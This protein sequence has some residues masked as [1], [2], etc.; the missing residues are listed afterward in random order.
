MTLSV[1]LPRVLNLNIEWSMLE[2]SELHTLLTHFPQLRELTLWM[3]ECMDSLSFLSPVRSTLRSLTLGCCF[4]FDLTADAMQILR[5][6]SLTHLTIDRGSNGKAIEPALLRAL[7]PSST[8]LPTLHTFDFIAP[9]KRV[10]FR[11]RV[12]GKLT[13]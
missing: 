8:L 4:G 5:T 7:T 12:S 6:F 11:G 1:A 2:T 9:R 10:F 13:Q 3:A